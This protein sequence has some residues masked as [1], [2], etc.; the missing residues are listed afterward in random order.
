MSTEER[1]GIMKTLVGQQANIERTRKRIFNLLTQCIKDIE[2]TVTV[3]GLKMRDVGSE[4]INSRQAW[5][6]ASMI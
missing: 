5:I 2:M 6:L 4:S 1:G 3:S